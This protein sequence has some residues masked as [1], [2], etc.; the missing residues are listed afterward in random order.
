MYSLPKSV[1]K[2][3]EE[4]GK[5]PGIGP[6]TALKVIREGKFDEYTEKIPNWKKLF[7]LFKNPLGTTDYKLDWRA[8]DEKKLK[9]IL[10]DRHDFGADRLASTLK[11]ITGIDRGQKGLGEF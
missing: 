6:K 9:E 3:I 7:D 8:P 4:L 11:R 5:L 10:V 1:A 2:L